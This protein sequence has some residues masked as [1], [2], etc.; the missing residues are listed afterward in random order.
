MLICSERGGAGKGLAWLQGA[1]T[2]TLFTYVSLEHQRGVGLG[3]AIP[4]IKTIFWCKQG[5]E[6]AN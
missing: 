6:E 5:D 4:V 2:P 3:G 1:F